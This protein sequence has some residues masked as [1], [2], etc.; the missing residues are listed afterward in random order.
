MKIRETL[1]S[2]LT[3]IMGLVAEF[4][5]YEDLTDYCTVTEDRLRE[6]IFGPQAYVKSLVAAEGDTV[7][8]YALFYPCFASFRGESGMYLE[9]I[10]VTEKHRRGGT[11]LMLIKAI[12]AYAAARGCTRIDFQVLDWNQPALSFYRKHGAESNDQET[13]FKFAGDAFAALA[14]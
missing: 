4:A 5:A 9:D 1:E 2:D 13:H 7:V 14:S 12:A 6:V 10:Y 8:G 11:G 3:A